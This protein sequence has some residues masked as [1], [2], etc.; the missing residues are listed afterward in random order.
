MV[1]SLNSHVL[2]VVCLEYIQGFGGG[3]D[4]CYL[5]RLKISNLIYVCNLFMLVLHRFLKIHFQ[6]QNCQ[7]PKYELPDWAL[8]VFIESSTSS[9]Q[10]LSFLLK[11]VSVFL[12]FVISV[13]EMAFIA[14]PTNSNKELAT[15]LWVGTGEYHKKETIV[16]TPKPGK[17]KTK[18]ELSTKCFLWH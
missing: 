7:N 17:N 12:F 4:F 9:K 10:R 13:G 3:G 8:Q 5:N 11:T 1:S 2:S 14:W 6:K 16:M 15:S 18:Y